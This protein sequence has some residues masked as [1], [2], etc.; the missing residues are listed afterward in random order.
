MGDTQAAAENVLQT[1]LEQWIKKGK[2]KKKKKTSYSSLF[3]NEQFLQ[4][5]LSQQR[6]W[7]GSSRCTL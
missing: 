1:V 7:S 5:A 4:G 6:R 3:N 2:E